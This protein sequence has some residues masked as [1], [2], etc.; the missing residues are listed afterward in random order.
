MIIFYL[1]SRYRSIKL[2]YMRKFQ[3]QN[4]WLAFGALA[5]ITLTSCS[6]GYGCPYDF[7]VVEDVHAICGQILN[8]LTFLF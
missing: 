8:V 3:N 1:C 4:R 6:R 5:I 7:S 2:Q